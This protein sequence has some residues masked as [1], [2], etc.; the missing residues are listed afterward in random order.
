G[1]TCEQGTL[2][3][4]TR[5]EVVLA[6]S[7]SLAL[8]FCALF[9]SIW[10]AFNLQQRMSKYVISNP[11][12]VYT[13]GRPHVSF[14][15]YYQCHCRQVSAISFFCFYLGVIALVAAAAILAASR[16]WLT[17]K[18]KTAAL[19]F[20][21]MCVMTLAVLLL[22]WR[23]FPAQTRLSDFAH[24]HH[25]DLDRVSPNVHRNDHDTATYGDGDGDQDDDGD[26]DQDD[27]DDDSADVTSERNRQAQIELPYSP[28]SELNEADDVESQLDRRHALHGYPARAP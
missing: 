9:L 11:R 15:R 16:F 1:H 13:C 26:A 28:R 3:T 20:M 10:F 6:Y 27:D 22:L 5:S 18:N 21:C 19:I 2:P 7:A 12:T 24:D 17:Y 8:A 14:Y 23:I 4:N 25:V